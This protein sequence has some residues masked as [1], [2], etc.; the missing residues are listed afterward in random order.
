MY[1]PTEYRQQK[2]KK[3]EIGNTAITKY[4]IIKFHF[5]KTLRNNR[6]YFGF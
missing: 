2:N 6:S 1:I 4:E 5:S 3:A